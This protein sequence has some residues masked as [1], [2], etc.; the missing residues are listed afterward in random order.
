M[1]LASLSEAGSVRVTGTFDPM[2][3]SI[4]PSPDGNHIYVSMLDGGGVADVRLYADLSGG[5]VERSMLQGTTPGVLAL[6]E[7]GDTM[8][9]VDS[10]GTVRV[11]DIPSGQ[12]VDTLTGVSGVDEVVISPGEDRLFL[13]E[14]GIYG[15]IIILPLDHSPKLVASRRGRDLAISLDGTEAYLLTAATVEVLDPI[16][17]S[18]RES[19]PFGG[20]GGALAAGT[21]AGEVHVITEEGDLLTLG[22]GGTPDRIFI[23]ITS[24]SPTWMQVVQ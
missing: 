21:R 13:A 24:S 17:L 12:N 22:G 7:S 23:G 11:I 20:T 5:L 15:Q 2:T 3:A 19:R 14:G 9:A 16:D 8:Y 4:I 18:F 6:N 10:N 1:D